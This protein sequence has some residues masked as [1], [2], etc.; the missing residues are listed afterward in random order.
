MPILP[1]PEHVYDP[2]PDDPVG[3]CAPFLPAPPD[4]LLIGG[5]GDVME[6]AQAR[7]RWPGCMIVGVDPD[8]RAVE[9]QRANGWPEDNSLM[10]TVALSD[11]AGTA[12]I[13]MDSLCCPSMH[14]A[15]VAEAKPGELTE[16]VTV[17]I[18]DWITT[19]PPGNGVLWLDL[20][21]WEATALRGARDLL[22]SGRATL[23][24]VEVWYKHEADARTVSRQL[25]A[26]GYERVHVWFRQWWGHNEFWMRKDRHDR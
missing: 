23:V 24:C 15:N 26:H 25:E 16:V 13:R 5:L 4:W 1:Y 20:E 11:R 8:P 10:L 12:T 7:K 18:D 3:V 19:L 9:W 2:S 14:P 22:A 21:G 6:A 17:T